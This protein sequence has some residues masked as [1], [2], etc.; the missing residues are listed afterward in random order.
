[1]LSSQDNS[2]LL[3]TTIPKLLLL[4]FAHRSL[5]QGSGILT[6][7]LIPLILL[8]PVEFCVSSFDTSVQPSRLVDR[9]SISS[10]LLTANQIPTIG[11][12]TPYLQLRKFPQVQVQAMSFNRHGHWDYAVR[13]RDGTINDPC[14]CHSGS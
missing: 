10:T 3:I 12:P 1:M 4:R 8:F 5:S 11:K 9:V 2:H 6:L 13:R 14:Q 7:Q